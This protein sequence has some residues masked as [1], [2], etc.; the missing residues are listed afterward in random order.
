MLK[1]SQILASE[2]A[3]L[4]LDKL[5]V[6]LPKIFVQQPERL[7]QAIEAIHF[8]DAFLGITD[9]A[10]DHAFTPRA[11]LEFRGFLAAE[12]DLPTA[13]ALKIV[14]AV[15][16]WLLA[17][18]LISEEDVQFA[19][20]QNETCAMR[21][22]QEASPL[23]ERIN[24]YSERFEIRDGSFAID[25][26]WLDSSLSEQSQQFLRERF[27]DY[28]RDKDAY[29]A[30]TDVELI[31]SVLLGYTARWPAR[32]LSATLTPKE[33]TT[34]IAEIKTESYR[35]MVFAGLTRTQADQNLKFVKNVI[36]HFFM[37]SGIFATVSRV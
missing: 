34:F 19:L 31:Y 29:Q 7:Q 17:G 28:L 25:L 12:V 8:F 22:Y 26:S 21:L 10:I 1:P 11:I 35:Q 4:R 33:T 16:D 15:G 6:L 5:E 9:A 32:E 24:Y 30:R 18:G 23:P 14:W 3:V 37:R 13:D 27:V 2:W 20:S 36:R